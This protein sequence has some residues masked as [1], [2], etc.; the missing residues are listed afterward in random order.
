MKKYSIIILSVFIFI[1]C[2]TGKYK[3]VSNL[4]KLE[5]TFADPEWNGK[6]IPP[7]G[8]GSLIGG[9]GNS[10]A[11]KVSNIPAGC[12]AIVV[13]FNDADFRNL[14]IAGGHGAIR[15]P[16]SGQSEIVVLSVPEMTFSLPL[17]V[18]V[19][20]P[21]RAEGNLPKGAYLGPGSTSHRYF[22]YVMAVYRAET[23]REESK[24]LGR[25]YIDFGRP[26]GK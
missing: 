6:K 10:P 22:A 26:D 3:P 5:V 2:S 15:V 24:L 21:H 17:G 4:S 12:N 9:P 11:L 23:E 20:H 19:E 8:H 1:N 14:S 13:E 25:G 18:F 7:K 16:V